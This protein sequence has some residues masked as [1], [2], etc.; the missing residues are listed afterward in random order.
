M[1][2]NP[3]VKKCYGLGRD[4]RLRNSEDPITGSIDGFINGKVLR[5][6]NS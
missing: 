2:K 4:Y 3:G 5:M 1:G 6:G